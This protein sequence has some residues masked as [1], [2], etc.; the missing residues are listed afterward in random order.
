MLIVDRWWNRGFRMPMDFS[1]SGYKQ[2]QQHKLPVSND[3][4]RSPVWMHLLT[5][6]TL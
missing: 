1:L 6:E 3:C 4:S 5:K 2:V